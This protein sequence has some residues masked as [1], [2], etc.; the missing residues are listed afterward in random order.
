M[1]KVAQN[2][3]WDSLESKKAFLPLVFYEEG[4]S[5]VGAKIDV[6]GAECIF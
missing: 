4:R 6:G 5:A 2:E 3:L 1:K